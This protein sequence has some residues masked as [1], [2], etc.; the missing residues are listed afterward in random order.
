MPNRSVISNKEALTLN[1]EPFRA[2]YTSLAQFEKEVF[3]HFVRR[4][5]REEIAGVTGDALQYSPGEVREERG[6]QA[7]RAV[8]APAYALGFSLLGAITHTIKLAVIIAGL[9]AIHPP[10]WRVGRSSRRQW[11]L[12]L[13]WSS[14]QALLRPI[15]GVQRSTPWGAAR[16]SGLRWR[17]GRRPAIRSTNGFG[18]SCW[19]AS[20]LECCPAE[21]AETQGR[22]RWMLDA[23]DASLSQSAAMSSST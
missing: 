8:V 19:R 5:V 22:G 17:P 4:Q 2:S 10:S 3:D 6:E 13:G 7:A 14:L 20:R 21:R 1:F 23:A 18:A 16:H 9:L 11:Q 12:S 15:R